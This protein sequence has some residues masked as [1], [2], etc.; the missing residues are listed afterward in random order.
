MQESFG[1]R[2]ATEWSDD[3]E[4]FVARVPALGPGCMAHGKTEGEATEAA[5]GASALILK[6][7]REDRKLIPEEDGPS[8]DSGQRS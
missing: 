8:D 7:L 5:R 2:I 6:V 4:I 3:D 1:Y